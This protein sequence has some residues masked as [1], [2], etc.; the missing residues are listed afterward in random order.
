VA[1]FAF[2][3]IKTYL[4]NRDLIKWKLAYW[5][6]FEFFQKYIDSTKDETGK[7]GI[8]FRVFTFSVVTAMIFSL[9]E[10]LLLFVV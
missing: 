5:N 1:A 4:V 2:G 3:A 6:P 8:W 10:I 9:V 7:A